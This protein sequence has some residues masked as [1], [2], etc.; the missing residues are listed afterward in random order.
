MATYRN[1]ARLCAWRGL[2]TDVANHRK[3]CQTCQ[4][5]RAPRGDYPTL[6]TSVSDQPFHTAASDFSETLGPPTGTGKHRY[7]VVFIGQL[8]KWP[9]VIPVKAPTTKQLIQAIP[10]G[11]HPPQ[12][13]LNGHPNFR[14]RFCLHQQRIPSTCKRQEHQTEPGREGQPQSQWTC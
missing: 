10:R 14:P 8:A 4:A 5:T 9:T 13:R 1:I 7:F 3:Q 2:F 6:K 12:T 11:E